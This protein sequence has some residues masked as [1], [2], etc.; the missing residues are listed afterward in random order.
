MNKKDVQEAAVHFLQS[1]IDGLKIVLDD[2]CN[3]TSE[4]SKSSA[5]DKHET[6]TSMAQ[7]EQEKLSKQLQVFLNQRAVLDRIDSSK[8][9]HKIE[10]GSLILSNKGWFYFSSGLGMISVNNENVFC[11][12]LQSP[13][14]ELLKGKQ[15]GE[16]VVF[17]GS[18]TSVLEVY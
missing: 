16:S 4:Y 13:I 9:H 8:M 18:T 6:A 17:N 14:G 2:I 10:I 15:K 5:G 3:S 11:L 1:K 12:A 7:L